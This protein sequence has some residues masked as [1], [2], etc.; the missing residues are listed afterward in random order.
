MKKTNMKFFPLLLALLLFTHSLQACCG[1]AIVDAVMEDLNATV[2]KS[3]KVM[4]HALALD[5]NISVMAD[6]NA[7]LQEMLK[8]EEELKKSIIVLTEIGT[9]YEEIGFSL[10]QLINVESVNKTIKI[11]NEFDSKSQEKETK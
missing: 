10:E 7:S 1:C 8:R 2:H 6:V 3:V 4:D 9:C 11:I 5:F